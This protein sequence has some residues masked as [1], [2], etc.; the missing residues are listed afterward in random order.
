MPHAE[1]VK[2]AVNSA[3]A[4]YRVSVE[5]LWMI[6]TDEQAHGLCFRWDKVFKTRTVKEATVS[7]AEDDFRISGASRVIGLV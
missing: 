2:K 1:D 5:P 6:Q 7:P 4:D 3:L